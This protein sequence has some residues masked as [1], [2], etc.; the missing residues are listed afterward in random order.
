MRA[1]NNCRRY[2]GNSFNGIWSDSNF[3]RMFLVWHSFESETNMILLISDLKR[4]KSISCTSSFFIIRE[5]FCFSYLRFF[6]QRS[7]ISL[8]DVR[9]RCN[10]ILFGSPSLNLPSIVYSIPMK[11]WIDMLLL[12]RKEKTSRLDCVLSLSWTL[13]KQRKILT[14]RIFSPLHNYSKHKC[15]L[16]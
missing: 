9:M 4:V 15:C 1:E 11:H 10:I 14:K 5:W 16:P 6:L 8:V 2:S 7:F 12:D 13:L 3:K